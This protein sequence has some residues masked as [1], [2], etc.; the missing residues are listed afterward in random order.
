MEAFSADTVL[1]A[2]KKARELLV[3]HYGVKYK[4]LNR[5]GGGIVS[6]ATVYQSNGDPTRFQAFI[7][8]SAPCH[9]T[10]LNGHNPGFRRLFNVSLPSI[11]QWDG[12]QF[13]AAKAWLDYLI[14]RSV[15]SIA[16]R[17][18]SVDRMIKQG[19]V[20][21]LP[22]RD[23]R[24]SHSAYQAAR[25]PKEYLDGCVVFK[26][27]VDEGMH[28]DMAFIFG[29]CTVMQGDTLEITKRRVH[30]NIHPD[31]VN[32]VNLLRRNFADERTSSTYHYSVYDNYAGI[33]KLFGPIAEG[34]MFKDIFN[35]LSET[36]EHEDVWGDK[37]TT[38]SFKISA[39]SIVN[40]NALFE[41]IVGG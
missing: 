26:R 22:D 25:M 21:S 6:Y 35:D 4:P 5:S 14:N 32:M 27:L 23:V 19:G 15:F 41:N 36:F 16:Y 2:H 20:V 7:N 31:S 9:G 8:I 3:R 29:Y 30:T 39:E 38:T 10:A 24:L 13:E 37:Y 18:K 1:E 40:A 33:Y 28:E 11:T 34:S 17:T 12:L